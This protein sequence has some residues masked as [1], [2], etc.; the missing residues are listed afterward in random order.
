MNR[1]MRTINNI[2]PIV[3]NITIGSFLSADQRGNGVGGD[4]FYYYY[5][6]D[7]P[8]ICPRGGRGGGGGD[9]GGVR[10]TPNSQSVRVRLVR[11]ISTCTLCTDP[12]A[13]YDRNNNIAIHTNRGYYIIIIPVWIVKNNI[14]NL[15]WSNLSDSRF[16]QEGTWNNVCA[17]L[18][19]NRREHSRCRAGVVSSATA[20]S[21][22]VINRFD[23]DVFRFHGRHDVARVSRAVRG[24]HRPV[25]VLGQRA[26]ATTVAAGPLVQPHVTPDQPDCRRVPGPPGSA[27]SKSFAAVFKVLQRPYVPHRT[28][29]VRDGLVIAKITTRESTLWV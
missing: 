23:S 4:Y 21:S 18:S 28:R 29:L 16:S 13:A 8:P 1:R 15:V 25:R 22:A 9:G 24:R 14:I 27:P 12:S 17:R 5:I 19:D 7:P 3:V 2:I 10:H 11:P 26:G 20:I 6:H